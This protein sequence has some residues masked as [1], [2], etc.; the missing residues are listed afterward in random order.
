[1]RR[2]LIMLAVAL[3]FTASFGSRETSAQVVVQSTSS[4]FKVV[5][6]TTLWDLAKK[7]TGN[8]GNWHSIFDINFTATILDSADIKVNAAG[9]TI[10]YLRPGDTILL[11]ADAAERAPGIVTRA[12]TAVPVTLPA[13]T[14]EATEASSGT[15]WWW[16]LLIPILF[17]AFLLWRSWRENKN[18][19]E[20]SSARG[21]EA[22]EYQR[23]LVNTEARL[24]RATRPREPAEM[25]T[26]LEIRGL[27]TGYRRQRT[28]DEGEGPSFIGRGITSPETLV[29]ALQRAAQIEGVRRNPDA[30]VVPHGSYVFRRGRRG[31]I[32]SG[33][34]SSLFS[35]GTE[36]VRVI[37][38]DKSDTHRI[39]WKATTVAPDGAEFDIYAEEVCANGMS[40]PVI[41]QGDL[42]WQEMPDTEQTHAL[43]AHAIYVDPPAPVVAESTTPVEMV[44]VIAVA[45]PDGR[46]IHV[47]SG[48]VMSPV[49]IP[50][51]EMVSLPQGSETASS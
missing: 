29:L 20:S 14:L 48:S 28:D 36:R 39:V 16:L 43:P 30:P 25:F 10:V 18:L 26:D 50:A 17:L 46:V 21:N 19:R 2:V 22:R 34:Y 49:Q 44:S 8:G 27:A 41:A 3:A 9:D 12:D 47:P 1:M 23:R 31:M 13:I 24:E 32:V 4:E 7:T 33:T 35:D 51:S 6:G 42:V 15:S 11:R 40:I 5:R 38:L 37:E 45:T